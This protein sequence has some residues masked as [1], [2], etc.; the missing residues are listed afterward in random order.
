[1]S[2]P[3]QVTMQIWAV[4]AARLLVLCT[5]Q[6][7]LA[8][9]LVVQQPPSTQLLVRKF[10][11][12]IMESFHITFASYS[13]SSPQY[14][15]WITTEIWSVTGWVLFTKY[16][17]TTHSLKLKPKV[18]AVLIPM[19]TIGDNF[20][21]YL[22][23]L[24]IV[25]GFCSGHFPGFPT[26]LLYAFVPYFSYISISYCLDFKALTVLLYCKKYVF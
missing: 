5:G 10:P 4:L 6:A 12:N 8:I 2:E 23:I 24:H 7:G 16:Y 17:S 25:I 26:K 14:C 3:F 15:V 22:S 13:N 19:S 21:P 18:S 9:L 11:I 1:M 20:C